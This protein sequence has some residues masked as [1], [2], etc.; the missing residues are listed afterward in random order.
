MKDWNEE[1]SIAESA[2]LL[3]E[4]G[5]R[6]QSCWALQEV[7]D[8]IIES[9]G[10]WWIA[11]FMETSTNEKAKKAL[12]AY[13]EKHRPADGEIVDQLVTAVHWRS[14][15]SGLEKDFGGD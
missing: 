9:V 2:T 5:N 13:L 11:H 1:Q 4:C 12:M 6:G 15:K 3:A 8:S 7:L 14:A 10:P